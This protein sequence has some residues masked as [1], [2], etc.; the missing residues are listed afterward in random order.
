MRL[1]PLLILLITFLSLSQAQPLS[2]GD[3]P[4]GF[5]GTQ[6]PTERAASLNSS[7]DVRY[8][9]SAMRAQRQGV[10]VVAAWI[11]AKGYVAYAEVQKGSG[12]ADLDA[13]A[14]R[15]V[16]NG[17]FKAAWREGKPCASRLSIPVEFRLTRNEE[18]YD[19]VK[20]QEQLQQEADEL[21]RTQQMLEE[22]QRALEEELRQLKEAQKKKETE[23]K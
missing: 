2:W 16:T 18:D 5:N 22:E 17:D 4:G 13:E 6:A 21:R 20:T 10:A 19:A 9:D 7:L 14:L 15:A 1:I 11:D 23:K 12:H 8:P 3:K